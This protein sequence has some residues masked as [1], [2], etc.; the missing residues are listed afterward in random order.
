MA[1]RREGEAQSRISVACAV[2]IVH[3]D[4]DMIA[5]GEV[6]GHGLQ[7]NARNYRGRGPFIRAFVP[8]RRR[9]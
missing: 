8:A 5:A 3:Q 9:A 6:A 1:A 7:G 4:N 2:Q